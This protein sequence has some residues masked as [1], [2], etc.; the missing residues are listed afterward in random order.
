M[1]AQETRYGT[2]RVE[3]GGV[4]DQT[5]LSNYTGVGKPQ[6]EVKEGEQKVTPPRT[7]DLEREAVRAWCRLVAPG[8]C[9]NKLV[10]REV[11]QI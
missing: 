8:Q 1:K 10:V 6:D 5:G 7:G 3:G 11:R 2:T 4:A 9:R